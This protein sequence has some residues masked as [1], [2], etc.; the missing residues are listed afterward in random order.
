MCFCNPGSWKKVVVISHRKGERRPTGLANKRMSKFHLSCT[1][2]H[3]RV[4]AT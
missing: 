2:S 1:I 4:G 3:L